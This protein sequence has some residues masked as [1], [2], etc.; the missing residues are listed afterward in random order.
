MQWLFWWAQTRAKQV[1]ENHAY[2]LGAQL[3]PSC[4]KLYAGVSK[5]LCQHH[6]ISA[7][8]WSCHSLR[9]RWNE[10]IH[11]FHSS[12]KISS[13]LCSQ[14]NWEAPSVS[15]SGLDPPDGSLIKSHLIS[16]IKI[17]LTRLNGERRGEE[18]WMPDRTTQFWEWDG[19]LWG[20]PETSSGCETE[21]MYAPLIPINH[22]PHFF[23]WV[24]RPPDV[25]I[26]DTEPGAHYHQCDHILALTITLAFIII[27]VLIAGHGRTTPVAAPWDKEI[28]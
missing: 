23:P 18:S 3:C 9:C 16:R 15:P 19:N 11:D 8:H 4:A 10:Y 6:M 20:A 25:P 26:E 12:C 27:Y 5:R 13:T 14:M 1:V 21:L 7:R 2:E 28:V 17:Q 24:V 22:R